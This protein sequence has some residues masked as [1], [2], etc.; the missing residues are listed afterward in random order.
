M[1]PM[2]RCV[3]PLL[4]ALPLSALAGDWTVKPEASTLGFT[5]SSQGEAFQG[6]FKQFDAK[7]RFD[8]KNLADASFD[9]TIPLASADTQNE[10][11]DSTLVGSDFFDVETHPTARFV[12]TQF[13]ALTDGG[14]EARGTLSLRGVDKPVTLRF[15]WEPQGDGARLEGDA[16]LDRTQFGV[17]GGDWEDAETI[18]HEVRVKTVLLL[19]PAAP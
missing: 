4:L 8:P 15:G 2:S 7:I 16:T 9:V 19:S 3:L 5:G 11:R 10:E 14:F 12:A 18:A 13:H 6:R 1:K 17:G